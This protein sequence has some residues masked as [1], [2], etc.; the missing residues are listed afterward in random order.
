MEQ[1]LVAGGRKQRSE[2]AGDKERQRG[3]IF[4]DKIANY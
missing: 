2:D 4:H 1:I 3:I